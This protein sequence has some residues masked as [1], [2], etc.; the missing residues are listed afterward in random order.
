MLSKSFFSLLI[1]A[2]VFQG[3]LGSPVET[4]GAVQLN[5][6]YISPDQVTELTWYFKYAS[7]AYIPFNACPKPNGQTFVTRISN[8]VTDTQ[9]YIARDDT[10]KEIIVVFRGSTS[11]EDFIITDGNIPLVPFLSPGLSAPGDV[12]VHSGFL[13]AWNSVATT[14]IDA[15]K[16][17]LIGRNGYTIVTVGHSLGGSLASLS[18]MAMKSNFPDVKVRMYTYG[19]PRTGNPDYANWV[20]VLF[21]TGKAYRVTHTTDP[22]PHLPEQFMGYAHHGTEY[23]ISHDP[24]DSYSIVSCNP[25]GEDPTCAN[26]VP[27]ITTALLLTAHLNVSS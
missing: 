22:V 19:Q 6:N 5:T 12:R 1:T 8:I 24:A 25:S 14:V 26:S 20:N 21:G 13:I 18:A 23:W 7:S 16:Q 4:T 15:V 17:Q 27:L 11:P 9:G 10:R 3:S 2:F